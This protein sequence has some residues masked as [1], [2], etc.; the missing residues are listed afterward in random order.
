M[1]YYAGIGSRE[2]PEN[3]LKLMKQMGSHLGK[4]G[5]TLRSGGAEGADQAFEEGCD[6]VNGPKE[7]YLPWRNFQNSHS[8]LI[9]GPPGSK[10]YLIAEEH[11]PYWANLS[12]GAKKLQARNS[13]QV[14]GK[15]LSTLTSFVVCYTAKGK[16]KGGTGQAIRLAKAHNIPIFDCGLYEED[17]ELLKDE[18]KQF[19]KTLKI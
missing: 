15:D 2:T 4:L 10:A 7:I 3:I 11:H 18:Y 13:H 1:I 14:L 9:V 16:G 5:I 8:N 12:D 17:L 6:M 19:L